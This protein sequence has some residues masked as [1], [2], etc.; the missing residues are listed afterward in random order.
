MRLNR[1]GWIALFALLLCGLFFLFPW[2]FQQLIG[3]QREFNQLLSDSLHRI[4]ADPIYAGMSLIAVS[5]FYGIFHALGPGHG[6]FI[7]T[8]YLATHQSKLT[9]SLRLSFLSSLMQGVV[10]I[11]ATSMIVLL[12]QLSSAQFKLS[13]LWLERIAYGLVFFLG[14]QWIRQSLKS[15]VLKRKQPK[16]KAIYRIANQVTINT[17][18]SKIGIQSA[19]KDSQELTCSCGHHHL[20]NHA[21][22][23][24]A[25]NFKSQCLIMLSIGM[26]PCTGA[27]F[28]LFLSYM[29]DLYVWGM[30]ATMAM[31]I[32]TGLTL[33][34][35]ALLVQY[36]RQTAMKLGKWYISPKLQYYFSDVLKFL[37][38][39]FL[40]FISMSLIYT[41]FL[42][43]TGGVVLFFN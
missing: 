7:I 35:F 1:L 18:T 28:I 37:V 38:A 4:Q 17:K 2:F 8:S 34:A 40:I 9:Q 23:A 10:A 29:L 5:L 3:F 43:K 36:A 25:N 39:L 31:A 42:P 33:S 16:M 41:S 19:V 30:V 12:L 15:V 13:Q 21:Q 24:K 22:L 6:K 26:R 11:L 14:L 20:P 27:I 32:G